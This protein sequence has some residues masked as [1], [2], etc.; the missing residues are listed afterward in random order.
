MA[1]A[2]ELYAKQ[3]SLPLQ[4]MNQI[5]F[6]SA[7]LYSVSEH[8]RSRQALHSLFVTIDHPC[9]MDMEGGNSES[10]GRG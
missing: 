1:G 7:R 2:K 8:K 3:M 6:D 9:I 10:L 4:Y 5:Q